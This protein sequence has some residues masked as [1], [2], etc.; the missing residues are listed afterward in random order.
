M[1]ITIE[2]EPADIARFQ[3]ALERA[4]AAVRSA[5]ECELVDSAKHTLDSLP[6]GNAPGFVRERIAQVQRLI[7]MLEDDTWALRSAR[8]RTRRMVARGGMRS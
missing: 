6:L 7:V 3:H 4:R 1:R 5:D 8:Y 2:L